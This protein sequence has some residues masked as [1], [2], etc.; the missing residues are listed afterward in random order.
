MIGPPRAPR[1]VAAVR[2]L[3]IPAAIAGIALL[4]AGWVGE[5]AANLRES[6][7]TLTIIH[8]PPERSFRIKGEPVARDAPWWASED[9]FETGAAMH[10][11][12][13]APPAIPSALAS[14][15]G[16]APLLAGVLH[17]ECATPRAAATW[18]AWPPA[19]AARVPRTPAQARHT[20]SPPHRRLRRRCRQS[21]S[22]RAQRSHHF[23]AS[24][25]TYPPRSCVSTLGCASTPAP[26]TRSS[27]APPG[28]GR[29]A[30]STSRRCAI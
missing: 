29:A 16:A 7:A 26:A 17:V 14:I 24:R 5:S 23:P 3:I 1:V 15:S 12:T 22:R 28:G 21:R 25:A 10:S 27:T 4:R 13:C 19:T 20:S 9:E 2:W 11:T 18:R 6:S 8:R 30:S